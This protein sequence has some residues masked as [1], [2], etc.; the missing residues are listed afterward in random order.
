MSSESSWYHSFPPIPS[1]H[2]ASSL[3]IPRCPSFAL[4]HPP[5]FLHL[6]L[7]TLPFISSLPF[8]SISSLFYI[9]SLSFLSS[10]ST[11]YSSYIFITS[12]LP[13]LSD[14]QQPI[15]A[16]G[17][18]SGSVGGHWVDGMV[19]RERERETERSSHCYILYAWHPL[20]IAATF[21]LLHL[22]SS[23]Y[24]VSCP[25]I[26]FST[27]FQILL[28]LTHLSLT[29]RLSSVLCQ[30]KVCSDGLNRE[31]ME[32]VDRTEWTWVHPWAFQSVSDQAQDLLVNS[33]MLD[34][35]KHMAKFKI[36]RM[37]ASIGITMLISDDHIHLLLPLVAA[38]TV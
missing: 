18:S 33:Q 26:C 27:H 23:T 24:L 29:L 30:S 13:P 35:A 38:E 6:P 37:L 2:L 3:L 8:T 36:T 9:I 17:L 7:P 32:E 22:H 12:T 21:L 10:I 14:I 20:S 11:S 19:L 28:T 31:I 4:Y 34:P 16:L 1:S 25:W 5:I 15:S